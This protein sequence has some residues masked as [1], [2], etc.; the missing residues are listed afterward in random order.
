MTIDLY[1]SAFDKRQLDKITNATKINI[2]P[3]SVE[4][5]SII[6]DESPVFELVYNSSYLNANYVYCSTF[7]RYYYVT[8]RRVNTAGRIEL[9]CY[10]DVRQSFKNSIKQTECTVIRSEAIA[11]PTRIQDTKLPIDPASKIVTSMVLPETTQ[12][13]S[14]NATYSYLLTVVGGEPNIEP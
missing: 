7:D 3:V 11:T 4:P 12:S 5:T 6:T 10:I 9:A 13:F 14:T 1:I 2:Q 8:E